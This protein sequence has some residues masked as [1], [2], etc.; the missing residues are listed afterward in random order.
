MRRYYISLLILTVLLTL[1]TFVVMWVAP[2]R[3]FAA[4]SRLPLYFAIVTGVLHW[5]ICKAMN[6]SPKRFVQ[7]GLAAPLCV[8]VLHTVILFVYLTNH[9]DQLYSFTLAFCIG[10]AIHL[11]FETIAVV[12]Y[13]GRERER[14]EKSS[15]TKE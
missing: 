7:V 1:A 4:I 12:R 15:T 14:R 9:L 10:F 6:R 5:V 8:I 11:V 3:Y 2:E 13:V